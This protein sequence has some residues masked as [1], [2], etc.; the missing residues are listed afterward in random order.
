MAEVVGLD[1]GTTN[2]LV[3]KIVGKRPLSLVDKAFGQNPWR[4]EGSYNTT[5]KG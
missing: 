2:S 1:F 3:S 5:S 4:Y